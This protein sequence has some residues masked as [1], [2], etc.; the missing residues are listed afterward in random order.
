LAFALFVWLQLALLLFML[1]WGNNGIPPPSAF[2]PTLLFSPHGLALLVT[3]TIVGG[4]LA[5]VV[6]SISVVSVPL[7]LTEQLDAV[8]AVR[9]S[10]TAIAQNP[11]P[12]ALWAALIAA[13]MAVGIATLSVGLVIAFPLVGHATWHAYRGM[14]EQR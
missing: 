7:L 4:C 12:L 5:A 9:T 8:T 2:V 11:K 1:F 13:F 14:V 10:L 6:F 3:G